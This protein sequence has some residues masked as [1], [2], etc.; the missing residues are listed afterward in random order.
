VAIHGSASR[1]ANAA[2]LISQATKAFSV[3]FV[4]DLDN[5]RKR[6]DKFVIATNKGITADARRFIEDAIQARRQVVFLDL[7]RIVELIREHHLTDYILFA[8]WQ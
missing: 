3:A 2:E 8:D 4:D 1:P 6:I 7:D 5:E